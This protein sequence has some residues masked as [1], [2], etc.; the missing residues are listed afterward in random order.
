MSDTP[1]NDD[2]KQAA[3]DYHRLEPKGKIKVTA[4]KP[5]VTQ[6]DL[7]LAYSPGVAFACEEI[8]ADPAKASEYTARGNL[9]AVISNGTAV[10]G[11]G[12]IG[13]LAGKP[14]MEGKGVLFQKFAG[15]D[16]F[17]L[18][19]NERDPD[20]L[21][22]IIASLEPTFGGIN[23]EDIKAP[24]C[25]IVER[26]LRERMQIP[27]FHDDQHG[28]AIIVGAAVLNALEVAGKDIAQVKLAT[29]G[30]GAAGIACLDMLVALGVNPQNILAFDRE[31]VIHS[32]RANLDPDKARYARDTGKRTLAEIV[33][34][35][36]VF[37]GLSAGGILKPEMVATM[38]NKPIILA[39][40][41]PYPEILPEDAKKVRP[42]AIIATG[43]SDY[44]NQVN[45][46][47]CFPYIFRGALDVGATSINEAMKLACVHAIA[48][49]ARKEASD[50]GSAY[51]G[52]VPKFGC[53]YLIPRPFDPRLLT[54]LAPAVAQAAMDS[55]I[56][57]RPIRDLPAYREKLGQFIHR[58]SL[59]MKPVYD[60]ARMH[61]KR[62]VYAEGEEY[63][64]LQ[65]VQAVIDDGLAFPVLI[66]RPEV[67][68][69]RIEKLGLRMRAGVDFEL[70]NINDDPR[71][72]DYWRQYH[73][74]T[75]RRGVTP[76]AAKNLLR[77]RPTLIAALMVERGEADALITGIVGR[78][79]KKLGY[80]R[81]V[82][83]FDA[84]VS[85]TA[86]MTA[87]INDAGAWFF[88]DTHVQLD[89]SAEQIAEATLQAAYRLKLLGIEPK[90]GLLSHSNY[91]SHQDPSAAKMRRAYE[92]VRQRQPKLEIDGEMMGDTAWDEVLRRRIFPNTTLSG[93]AN[94]LV[95]PN[96]DAANIAYNLIRV[97]T[98][99]VAIGP[100]LM[101]LDKTAHILTPASSSR[102]IVN[103]TAIAAVEAHIRAE[104]RAR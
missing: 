34:G 67:I 19:V 99:G 68:E 91:G 12:D 53:E 76:D 95:F 30:A 52:D 72:D 77:S 42:D 57:L 4:T 3:L 51:G 5:M 74:L 31:G 62:V 13:P 18:E 101:G 28:T 89:P 98:G 38:A 59:M 32:G 100:I 16:V 25:F 96:L 49:L 22:D 69:S 50:L 2:L 104:L 1:A 61:R 60:R 44:P 35:A 92:I 45:N 6:R 75:E 66:G 63:V 47:V 71:F 70:T 27:V 17:D 88:V 43:R 10:L 40:A 29:T 94:L 37:L 90:I 15:I 73:A 20:K 79:H 26:K 54:S 64:V 48:D 36:D 39:L 87:V 33:D 82:F 11:L 86:A 9:V 103:M 83:N 24:E 80:L 78:Y 21:V 93:S 41:N 46:A 102:R 81:S 23:L 14:V 85:G 84:G 58:T 55:G 56:A 65:A 8:A 97:A 7:A